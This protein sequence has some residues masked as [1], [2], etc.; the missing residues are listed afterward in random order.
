MSKYVVIDFEYNQVTEK[1]LNLVCVS[2]ETIGHVLKQD[3][4]LHKNDNDHNLVEA[5]QALNDD[6]YIFLSYNVVAE[7]SAFLALGLDPTK[8]KWICLFTEFRMLTNSNHRLQYGEHYI[9]GKVRRLKKPRPK[10]QQNEKEKGSGGKLTH[11]LSQAVFKFLGKKIDTEHK[12]AM[13]DL[14]ISQPDE[15]TDKEKTD[16]MSYCADDIKYLHPMFQ[17]MCGWYKKLLS[18]ADFATIKEDM[19]LRGDTMARTAIMERLGYH[20]RYD[21]TK[22]FSRSTGKILKHIQRDINEQF[23]EILPF[24]FD[25]KTFHYVQKRLPLDNW[26]KGQGLDKSWLRTDKKSLSHSLDAFGEHFSFRHSYPRGNFGAQMVRFLK[27]KQQLNGF[28]P[29]KN[30]TGKKP[31][32]KFWDSVGSDRIVRPYLNP[33]GSQTARYQPSATSFIFLKAAWMRALVM[34]PKG[35]MYCGIDYKAQEFY[36]AALLSGDKRM[37]QDYETGDPYL[38][39]GKACGAIPKDGTKASHPVMRQACKST[40]LGLSFQM[41]KYGLA[42]KLTVD[43][44]TE[45][46]EEQAQEWVERFEQTYIDHH[47]WKQEMIEKYVIDGYLKLPD[48]WIMFGDNENE[49]SVGN[50]PVQGFGSCI[51]RKA[52]QLSQDFGIDIPWPLHD[53]CYALSDVNDWSYIEAF[54]MKMDEAFKYYFPESIQENI[55]VGLDIECWGPDL[56]P[57][58]IVTEDG[59][60]VKTENIHIDE[61][62]LEEYENFHQ[63]FEAPDSDLL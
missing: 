34:P 41:T 17:K 24:H 51:L 45:W 52:I 43:T 31:R 8:F 60:K 42:K 5:L 58:E 33:Y 3:V 22:N 53:A 11:N 14:I 9:D 40:V 44:G 50:F 19:L 35:E 27:A 15:F 56:L 20:I 62:A 61:R 16:I 7:A 57:G 23:P 46:S 59:Y 37:I 13:R 30:Q 63:Y 39:F 28:M 12:E 54:A 1:S 55:N 6:G 21:E 26:I 10:W 2:L 48:G 38:A 18:K 25:K 47:Y 32:K 49:R 4:W 36:I 29:V